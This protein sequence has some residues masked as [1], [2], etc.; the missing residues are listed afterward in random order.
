LPP[1]TGKTRS[2]LLDG[3]EKKPEYVPSLSRFLPDT[4][5]AA[6][7]VMKLFDQE[8]K[9]KQLYPNWTK[10]VRAW[11]RHHSKYFRDE[12]IQ[13]AKDATF[14]FFG[15]EGKEDVLALVRLDWEQA[16]PILLEHA[17]SDEPRR[18][19]GATSI[20][21]ERALRTKDA[22]RAARLR[23]QLQAI[24]ADKKLPAH[25][26]AIACEGLL[27]VEWAGRDDWYLSLFADE[28][29]REMIE[30]SLLMAPLCEP[31]RSN[32]DKWIPA[33]AKLVA[34]KDRAVHDTAVSCLIQFN[35]EQA[36]KDALQPLLPWLAD[37]EW[38]SARERL[39]LIQSL[40]R[41]DLPESVPGLIKVVEREDEFALD[42]A[43][44]ALAVYRDQRAIPALTK[45][46]AR[47]NDERT[48]RPIVQALLA[49]DGLTDEQIAKAVEAYAVQI[50]TPEGLAE[51]RAAFD[52]GGRKM[53]PPTVSLGYQVYC[54]RPCRDQAA[55]MLFRRAEALEKEKQ[56]VAREMRRVVQAWPGKAVDSYILRRISDGKADV[57]TLE[58]ALQRRRSLRANVASDLRRLEQKPGAV[59]GCA[60][61]LAGDLQQEI[62][63]L[64]GADQ[65]AQIALLAG[66]RL[67]R[68]PLPV[69]KVGRL[70]KKDAKD[71][72][73]AAERFLES[74]DS[75]EARQLVQDQ[76][77][78][79]VLILGAREHFDPGHNTYEQFDDWE[80]RL[81]EEIR[82]KDGP[83]EVYA[84][85]S[86]GYWGNAGQLVIRI[87]RRQAELS[88]HGGEKQP[89]VRPLVAAE[90]E[91]LRA[92][93]ADNGIDN[94]PPLNL[95]A[96]DGIQYEYVHLTKNGGRRVFM[97]NPDL[98]ERD[99]SPYDQLI[100]YFTRLVRK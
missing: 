31:V 33:I 62:A 99:G 14:K 65:A 2:R 3:C 73:L 9:A 40:D 55:E 66:A 87:R 49:C 86:A 22:E 97:N 11:L 41:V 75:P 63:V 23:K 54:L 30:D 29:L 80:K 70:L 47:D 96:A 77:P 32:P 42:G 39:R 35:L 27:G 46:L 43:A 52:L 19:A 44:T 71:L 21:F 74:E 100:E 5:E 12:L 92:V 58:T 93:V 13:A 61:L 24:V 94:L 34:N 91:R 53:L 37:A 95:L 90:L 50:S 51:L 76:H 36:R 67:I 4:P 79:E 25:A 20:L 60:A 78:G 98:S 45:A 82:A 69:D 83:E 18:T 38:S 15:Q 59:R 26:R 48:R 81:R 85:L 56:R 8:Q 57:N 17:A 89:T 72:A 16:E 64:E 10:Q 6:E 1:P 68:E 7:R 84:L 88:V 28:T